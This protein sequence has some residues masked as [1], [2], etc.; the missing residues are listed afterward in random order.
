MSQFNVIFKRPIPKRILIADDDPV[1]RHL[2]A[3]VVKQQREVVT[4]S[5]GR[6][7]YRRRTHNLEPP[8]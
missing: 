7:A 1:I 6:E 5:D 4:A 2:L 8:F 3:A